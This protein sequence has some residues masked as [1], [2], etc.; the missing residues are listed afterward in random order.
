MIPG[1]MPMARN[2]C[3]VGSAHNRA[4][5]LSNDDEVENFQNASPSKQII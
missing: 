1:P 4:I 5:F 2:I 3:G